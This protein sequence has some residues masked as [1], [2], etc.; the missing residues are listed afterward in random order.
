MKTLKKYIILLA[1]LTAL[2]LIASCGDDVGHDDH[3][4]DH[5]GH[6][7]ENEV[8][9]TL[10]LTF[11]GSDGNSAVFTW[12]D[13]EDDG[14]PVIDDI[15]LTNGETYTVTLEVINELEDPAE[16]ITPE[17]SDEKDEHQVFFTGTA[18]KGPANTANDAAVIEHSYSDTDNN[19]F[20]IGLTNSF[21][22]TSAGTGVLNVVLRHMPPVNG[23]PVKTGDL[24]GVMD[25][26]KVTDL[27]GSTDISVDF[28]V[29][30]Q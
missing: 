23:T 26:G 10:K 29:S 3:D 16:D 20:P 21:V 18:V 8:M 14:S 22:A 11:A 28:N 5:H 19:G 15:S 25:G 30:V 6:D 17:I 13:P 9:T 4:H 1:S 27:P 7:H 24:A 2:T 12:A